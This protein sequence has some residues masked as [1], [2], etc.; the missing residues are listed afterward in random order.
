MANII[1]NP[2]DTKEY[3]LYYFYCIFILLVPYKI[4]RA[5]FYIRNHD[6]QTFYVK[7][8]QIFQ[9]IHSL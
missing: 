9:K 4:V 1:C 2:F 3:S 6:V 7:L 5:F 8:V